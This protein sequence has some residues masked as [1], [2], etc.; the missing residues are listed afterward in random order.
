[1]KIKT[2]KDKYNKIKTLGYTVLLNSV[3]MIT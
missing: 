3:I 1:M 2:I